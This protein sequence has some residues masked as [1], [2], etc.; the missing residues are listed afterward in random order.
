VSGTDATLYHVHAGPRGEPLRM[1]NAAR[2][3]VWDAAY[4]P[5]GA[6]NVFSSTT[7][8]DIRLPGQMLHGETGL[9]QNWHRDHDPST[10]RYATP[11]PIGL[12]GGPSVYQYVGGDP[13]S[14]VDPEGLARRPHGVPTPSIIPPMV[15]PGTP[16]NKAFVDACLNALPKFH[17]ERPPGYWP[18]DTGAREWGRRNGVNPD[19]AR[20][21]AHK[22]KQDDKGRGKDDYGA[23]PDTGDV[24]GPDGES[25]GNL[26][27]P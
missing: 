13:M 25:A 26:N 23:N 16:D 4:E 11:D 12:D 9:H 17:S 1:T 8:L 24:I 6:A 5:F 21:R 18:L 15:I 22:I 14:F 27:D 3:L 19:D 20:R 7:Q 2:A 10:G